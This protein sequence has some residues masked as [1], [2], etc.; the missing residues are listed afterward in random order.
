MTPT[1][2]VIDKRFDNVLDIARNAISANS[3]LLLHEIDTTDIMKKA[4]YEVPAIR[5]LLFFHPR[6]MIVIIEKDHEFV[7]KAPLKIVI[8]S[9][10][11]QKTLI[12]YT[13]PEEVFA[14]SVRLK[15][16]KEELGMRVQAVLSQLMD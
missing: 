6:Y 14:Q 7:I 4:G 2:I 8:Q 9:I 12:T 5:Q 1:T 10:D 15:D 13:S 3:F 16:L 11:H